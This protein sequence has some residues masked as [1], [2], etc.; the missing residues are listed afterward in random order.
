L[1]VDVTPSWRRQFED[2]LR[3]RSVE[4]PLYFNLWTMKADGAAQA[5]LVGGPTTDTFPDC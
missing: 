2:R 4:R 5:A 1:V 3:Q